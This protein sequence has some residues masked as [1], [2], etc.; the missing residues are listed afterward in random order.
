M[1]SLFGIVRARWSPYCALSRNPRW[2]RACPNMCARSHACWCACGVG[3]RTVPPRRR[4]SAAARRTR[5]VASCC[6]E[7]RAHPCPRV[8]RECSHRLAFRRVARYDTASRPRPPI[9]RGVWPPALTIQGA[10]GIGLQIGCR[11]PADILQ[12]GTPP[13]GSWS[14]RGAARQGGNRSHA[15]GAPASSHALYLWWL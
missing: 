9:G 10:P 1:P 4:A 8:I 6:R 15:R 12:M 2:Y 13:C 7:R 3:G 5:G 11:Y 14:T